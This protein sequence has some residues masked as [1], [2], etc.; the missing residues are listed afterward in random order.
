[1][2]NEFVEMLAMRFGLGDE[3]ERS[4]AS[5]LSSLERVLRER[6]S[7][8]LTTALVVDEAQ[9]LSEELLEE[10]RLLANLET[11]TEKLLPIV[12]AGQPE[13]AALRVRASIACW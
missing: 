2:F 6:R 13:L 11:A 10:I 7:R 1:M 8:G 3:A 12:L 9:S 4:K 5:L